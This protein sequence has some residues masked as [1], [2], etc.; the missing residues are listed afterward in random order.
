MPGTLPRFANC[1]SRWAAALA[2]TALAFAGQAGAQVMAGPTKLIKTVGGVTFDSAYDNGSLLDVVSGGTNIFN[3]TLY[4]DSGEQGTAKYWFRFRM[5]GVAGRTVRVNIDHVENARPYVKIGS[6]AW[7]RTTAAEAPNTGTLLFTFPAG[8]NAAELAFFEPY[9]VAEISQA[10]TARTSRSAFATSSLIAAST[11]GRPL[12]MITIEDPAWPSA[13][14][15]RIWLHSRV[16]AGE[17]TATHSMLGFLDQVLADSETGR[18][19]RQHCIFTIVPM[20]NADGIARGHTRW[21]SLGYDPERE[22]CGPI[23][24]PEVQA[25]KTN[26]DAFMAGPNPILVA[27]NLHSTKG[28]FADSFFF[29]HLAPSVSAAFET[30]QQNYINAVNAAT[31]LFNNA[32]PQTSQLSACLFIESYF[33]NNWGPSVMALTHEGHYQKRLTD[34]D[35]ITGADYREIGAALARGLTTYF[36]LP[37]ASEPGLTYAS[38]LA[39]HFTPGEIANPSLTG[40]NADPDKDGSNNLLEYALARNPRFPDLA[41]S[42]LQSVSTSPASL[43]LTAERSVLPTD[44]DVFMERSADLATWTRL[45]ENTAPDPATGTALR[46]LSQRR[47]T[48]SQAI[49]TLTLTA[50]W[51]APRSFYRLAV[52][53]L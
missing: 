35:W 31:P 16:H 27:L 26:V 29:K 25:L 37:A 49:T 10:V 42:P 13:G 14:K 15:R 46:T 28:N 51:S 19:L 17:V 21:D 47:A 3:A 38:W 48:D 1:P 36:P 20:V 44:L 18:R 12:E 50:P 8:E 41:V 45:A 6:A 40:D 30:I 11:E 39:L 2:V 53:R 5:T 22:W 23:R 32:S 33:W 4:T 52:R 24:I 9:G 7:R 43:T 34:G